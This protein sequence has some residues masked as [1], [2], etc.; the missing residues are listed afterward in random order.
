MLVEFLQTRDYGTVGL[1]SAGEVLEVDDEVGSQ[2]IGQGFAKR[3]EKIASKQDKP[4]AQ[5][6]AKTRLKTE[7]D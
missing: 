2:F 6:V 4:E 1:K 3:H 5:P 7:E